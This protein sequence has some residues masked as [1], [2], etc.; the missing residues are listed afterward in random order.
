MI[1]SL[2]DG[3]ACVLADVTGKYRQGDKKIN[4]GNNWCEEQI[5]S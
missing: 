3:I 1:C 4:V 5:I 2:A